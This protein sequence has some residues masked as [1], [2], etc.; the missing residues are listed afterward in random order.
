MLLATKGTRNQQYYV[1]VNSS[2]WT[3]SLTLILW[4]SG[5]A[6]LYFSTLHS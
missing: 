6:P 1:Y 5:S 2:N 4:I 3:S